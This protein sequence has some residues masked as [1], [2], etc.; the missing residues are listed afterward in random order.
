MNE[1]LTC[2]SCGYSGEH[3][4]GYGLAAGPMGS[5]TFCAACNELLEFIPDFEG[6]PEE[7][8]IKVKAFVA[9]WRKKVWKEST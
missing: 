2:P 1:P 5:Y 7:T 4:Q 9:D 3:N 8:V 6:I